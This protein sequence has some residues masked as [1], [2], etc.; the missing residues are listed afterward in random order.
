[1]ENAAWDEFSKET[2]IHIIDP[3]L[4]VEDFLVELAQ[5]KR[6]LCEAM[7]GAILADTFNIPWFPVKMYDHIN[8]EKWFDWTEAFDL[9][10]KFDYLNPIWKG[11][12]GLS[13]KVRVKNSI[14][15]IF[16][17][18]G[19]FDGR[20]DNVK[21]RTSKKSELNIVANKMR[22]LSSNAK[23]FTTD[24]DIMNTKIDNLI[25]KIET[26]FETQ[27]SFG[28]FEFKHSDLLVR[29]LPER[30]KNKC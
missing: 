18:F 2:G 14:K 29:I 25:D 19:I 3:R 9:K 27:V 24:R 6:V 20:F 5:T 17:Y 26:K 4:P 30:I 7:H 13:F 12:I 16:K 15:R 22:K 23:F 21:P 1:M 10:I 11:D 28:E 8:E